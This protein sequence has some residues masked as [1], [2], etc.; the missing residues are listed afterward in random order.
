MA[1]IEVCARSCWLVVIINESAGLRYWDGFATDE[2]L[3]EVSKCGT[4]SYQGD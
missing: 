1:I 4:P 2:D 3:Y